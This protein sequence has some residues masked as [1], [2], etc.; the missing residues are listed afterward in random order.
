MKI[1]ARLGHMIQSPIGKRRLD[2][3]GATIG[4]ARMNPD[5]AYGAIP[6]LL[7]EYIDHGSENAWRE[8]RER[9]DNVYITVSNA[10]EALDAEEPFFRNIVKLLEAGGKLFFKP[11]VVTLP[12][13]DPKTHD[14]V[15][16]GTC[17]PWEFVAALMR[18]F[19]DKRGISYHQ[20]ALGE[21]GTSTSQIA[22]TTSRAF[23]ETV[24]TQ[25]LLEGTCG[26]NYGGWGFYFARKYLAECHDISHTDDPMQGYE[27]SLSGVCLPPGQ[28]RDKLLIYDL[29]KIADDFSNGRDVPVAD[30]INYKT[31]TLH[32]AIIGG[33]PNDPEDLRN[34]PRCVLVNV[35]KLKIHLQELFTGAIKNLGIG[36]YPMEVNVSQEPGKF[37]WKYALPN[38][39][40]PMCKMVVPHNRWSV[41]TDVETGT[42]IRDKD[43]EYVWTESGGMEASMS[44][45]IQA[46]RSQGIMTLHVVDA[47]DA[48]NIDH[49]YPGCTPVPEGFVFASNDI[50]AVDTC[51]SRYLFTMVPMAEADKIRKEHNLTS[52][53]IQKVPMPRIEGKNIVTGEGYDSSFSRYGTLKHCEDRRLGQQR[54]YVVGNDLWQGGSLAS[55]RQHLG[56]V[57]NGVFTELLTNT[58]YH[59][60]NKPLWDLQ[61]TSLAYLELNDKLTGSDF[62][63]KILEAYD[64]NR[65]GVIDYQESGRNESQL[66]GSYVVMLNTQSLDRLEKLK[67]RFLISTGQL[68]RFK[69]EW[70]PDGHDIGEQAMMA[71]ALA[72]ALD[73]ANSAKEM[74][75]PFFPRMA[76][77]KGKWPSLQFAMH[78]QILTLI[79]GPMFP[80]QFDLK[81]SPYGCAFCYAD[82]KWNETRYNNAEARAR[83]EDIIGNYHKAV[84]SGADLLPFTLYIPLELGTVGNVRV[85][86]VEETDNPKLM[87]TASF[88]G[89][90]VWQDLQLS[91]FHLK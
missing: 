66:M 21:A 48:V 10:M 29:N 46:V 16:I 53:V 63:R 47:I 13:I 3:T 11:N 38:L 35:A 72:K 22:V 34:W 80:D 59:T 90:E 40:V 2:N 70:N 20:M 75:D 73:M 7:K 26:K 41:E 42:P 9:I 5:K 60:P 39:Y 77:G 8:I 27:E 61:A 62:K 28:V 49:A 54:F 81:M 86:N 17:T 76:C 30:G 57:N 50:V 32:K 4:A 37:K 31:I 89:K 84:A 83:N 65:D 24:T 25:A 51:C 79:Y 14:P 15:L 85:P 45:A 69:K 55:L 23:G 36:L 58:L 71:Q 18:W 1:R 88:N 56:R 67:F 19:H 6:M 82:A 74:P 44:D 33:N 91:S 52:D 68:Q 12:K 87:F 64:E 78:Q 43:G